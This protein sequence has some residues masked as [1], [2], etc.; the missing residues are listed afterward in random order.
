MNNPANDRIL[1][2]ASGLSVSPIG[3]GTNSWNDNLKALPGLQ[4]TF[5][6][7]LKIG[8]NFF[9]T[10]EIYNLGGSERALGQF[11]QSI[12]EKPIIATKYLPLPWRLSKTSLVGALRGSLSRLQLSQV[13]LYL[14][15]FPWPPVSVEIWASELAEAVD[16]GLTRAVGVSNFNPLQMARAHAVL[17]RQGIPLACNQVEY[18]LLK[19]GAERSGL[20][21]LCRELNVTLIAYRPITGGLLTGRYTPKN[22]PT[23][24]RRGIYTREY[25]AKIQPIVYLL[26]KIGE[27][28]GGKK[29]SQV[30]LNWLI[31][32]GAVPIPGARSTKHLEEN[33][34]ALGW[35]LSDDE[36][37]LLDEATEKL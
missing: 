4:S 32:K 14:I 15:H 36:I 3:I 1:L 23:T 5:E 30:A 6:E 24:W 21:R 9:D 31:C 37:A 29:P 35:R 11:V 28:H 26:L 34:G 19:R 33:A 8:I 2:G 16:S 22:P 27:D 7:A 10:A 13:D 25:V 20:S 17:A 12:N 18:S